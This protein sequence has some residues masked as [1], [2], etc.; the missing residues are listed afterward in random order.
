[1]IHMETAEEFT[2]LIDIINT[3]R[4]EHGCPWDKKQTPQ[5]FKKYLMEESQELLEAL[6]REDEEHI[7][8]ELGDMFF[9]L[10][11]LSVMYAE[12]KAFDLAAPLYGINEKMIRRHPHVFS[13]AE[14][15]DEESLRRQWEE[16]KRAEKAGS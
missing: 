11:M 2:R 8:E 5:S 10:S 9:V 6:E 16:I 7:C 13:H 15:I 12:K 4:G 1:M 3:L 14:Y